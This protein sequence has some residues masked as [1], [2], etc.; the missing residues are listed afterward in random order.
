MVLWLPYL[1]PATRPTHAQEKDGRF[2]CILVG[3]PLHFTVTS[4]FCSS[5][6]MSLHLDLEGSMRV[7]LFFIAS[8]QYFSFLYFVALLRPPL[9]IPDLIRSILSTTS[10]HFLSSTA[11][12]VPPPEVLSTVEYCWAIELQ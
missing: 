5:W 4:V 2:F 10:P 8:F 1:L 7:L 3:L 6:D 9:Y 11:S 12:I